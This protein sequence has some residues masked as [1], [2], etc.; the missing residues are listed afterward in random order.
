MNGLCPRCGKVLPITATQG[1]EGSCY[2]AIRRNCDTC[3]L[4]V[5]EETTYEFELDANGE[6]VNG[7]G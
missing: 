2:Y 7:P 6:P 5:I 1:K 3:K 4:Q